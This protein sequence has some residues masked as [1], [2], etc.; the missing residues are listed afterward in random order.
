ME[1]KLELKFV[2]TTD[3]MKICSTDRR[4]KYIHPARIQSNLP[5][6]NVGKLLQC[7]QFQILEAHHVIFLLLRASMWMERG[8]DLC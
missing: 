4:R 2:R 5:V 3:L 8:T 1:L 7:V 6:E